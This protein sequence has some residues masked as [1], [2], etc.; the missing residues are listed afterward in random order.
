MSASTGTIRRPMSQG[1][2]FASIAIGVVTLIAIGALAVAALGQTAPKQPVTPVAAPTYL[3]RGA[4]DEGFRFTYGKPAS[5][6]TETLTPIPPDRGARDEGFRFTFGN[7]RTTT[8][9]QVRQPRG[10]R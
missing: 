1:S 7:A 4:R 3:D 6:T 5:A 9:A 2:I 8:E 10:V